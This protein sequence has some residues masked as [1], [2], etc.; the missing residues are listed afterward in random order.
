MLAIGLMSGTSMDGIDAVLVD[1]QE[2][3]ERICLQLIESA[4]LPYPEETLRGLRE[5]SPPHAGTAEHLVRMHSHL[6]EL[7]AEAALCVLRKAGRR[8]EEIAVIGSHGQTILNLPPASPPFTHRVRVQLGEICIIAERTGITTVGDFRVRDVA[9]G[10]EGA[11]LIP[12]F[13]YR[14]F[15]A[16][17][18][19]NRLALNLGGIANVTYLPAGGTLD[20]VRAFDTGP[21]GMI[22]DATVRRLTGGRQAYDEDGRLADSGRAAPD[23]LVKL[24]RH[25]FI[26][27]PP[28]KSA[29]REEFGEGFVTWLLEQPEAQ[30]LSLADLAATLVAFTVQA[31]AVNCRTFLGPVEEVIASGGGAKNP[32]FLRALGRAF[33]GARVVTSEAYGIP[34]KAKE[35]MGFALLAYETL[36]RRPSNVPGATGARRRVVLGK[37]AWA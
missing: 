19:V 27:A 3:G 13:D 22:L 5:L 4:A 15:G 8:P 35:A 17:G 7:F 24:L 23:L 18:G 10:G 9:A 11:P 28:P 30:G 20:D 16:G 2:E 37:V 32:A 33:P 34:I 26:S 6:G 1:I 14:V 31:V 36:H 12:Y 29:G 25:P 21:G